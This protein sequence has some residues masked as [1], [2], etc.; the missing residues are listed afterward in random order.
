[1]F[2][3]QTIPKLLRVDIIIITLTLQIESRL[4]EVT[5]YVW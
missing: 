4:W 2:I 5:A 3:V 1:M